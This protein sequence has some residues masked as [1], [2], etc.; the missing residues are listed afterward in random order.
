M[1]WERG[2]VYL[3]LFFSHKNQSRLKAVGS[4]ETFTSNKKVDM[5]HNE[6]H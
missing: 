3:K 1:A 4:A 5:K 6:E 2:Y